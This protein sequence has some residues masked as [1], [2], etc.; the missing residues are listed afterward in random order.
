[1]GRVVLCGFCAAATTALAAVDG[2]PAADPA[3]ATGTTIRLALFNDSL[4]LGI[5]A[6]AALFGYDEMDGNDEGYTHG[7][8]LAVQ[9]LAENGDTTT[10]A[11]GT[12][13]YL[14]RQ[15]PAA[16]GD[17]R[18]D[19]PVWATEEE[20]LS[21]RVDTRRRGGRWF[22]EYGGGALYDGKAA[23]A[24]GA[25]GQQRWFHRYFNT[26]HQTTYRI[27]D[28]GHAGWGVFVRGGYGI[29]G[30]WRFADSGTVLSAQALLAAEPNTMTEASQL[31]LGTTAALGHATATTKVSLSAAVA[32]VVHPGGVGY[33]PSVEL[34]YERRTWGICSAVAFPRG[35]LRN[36]TRY[37]DDRD[38]ISGLSLFVR[39]PR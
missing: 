31:I 22:V 25:S 3:A 18:E 33:T 26:S 28:D 39:I 5:G 23:T 38:P 34:A 1:M 6:V 32:T 14:R 2:V 7:A 21:Y 24:I 35:R 19:V 8:E 36:H 12:R 4:N 37:N 10:W 29:Q 27:E 20:S 9:T 11:L 17:S 30:Q 16:E 15:R 13:L